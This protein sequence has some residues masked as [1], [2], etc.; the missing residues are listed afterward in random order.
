M[1]RV[2]LI[3][4]FL[5]LFAG[6][7]PPGMIPYQ[8]TL[9][10]P[11]GQVLPNQ[12]VE[13]RFVIHLNSP[14]NPVFEEVHSAVSD[15]DGGVALF[16]GGGVATS[17]FVPPL[18]NVGWDENTGG[19]FLQTF[20][21]MGDAETDVGITQLMSVPF[22]L[23]AERSGQ[24]MNGKSVMGLL[25]DDQL[26]Y[27]D[28]S[29]FIIPGLSDANLYYERGEGV[30]DVDGNYYKS[31]VIQTEEGPIEFTTTN[32]RSTKLNDGTAIPSDSL[33]WVEQ[34]ELS[35]A[36]GDTVDGFQW[37]R[38]TGDTVDGLLQEGLIIF[39]SDT[40]DGIISSDTVDGYISFR[41]SADSAVQR[42]AFTR[43]YRAET[44]TG[45]FLDVAGENSN[46]LTIE[47]TTLGYLY[48]WYAVATGQLCP[49]GWHAPTYQEFNLLLDA[50]DSNAQTLYLQPYILQG[51][52]SE[53]NTFY[54]PTKRSEASAPWLSASGLSLGGLGF[55][56]LMNGQINYAGLN[57]QTDIGYRYSLLETCG[58]CSYNLSTGAFWTADQAL[59]GFSS[60]CF[61]QGILPHGLAFYLT[62]FAQLDY[63]PRDSGLSVRCVRD[64]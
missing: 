51:D 16:I 36:T 55:V 39:G 14:D 20:V 49:V 30:T 50:L 45:P 8:F 31:A 18:Q 9:R 26:V 61:N 57:M 59:F 58:E 28:S 2:L 35:F 53:E 24:M 10:S 64:R 37:I 52:L 29:I 43:P 21:N 60:D 13:V 48:N 15:D 22:A 34:Q 5:P 11:Q 25:P 33:R 27:T 32:L 63:K 47:D 62:E 17:P 12:T 40:V 46:C 4:I 38:S 6:A 44:Q 19:M 7:Q 1:L 54:L 56:S 41:F 42:M 3:L 23:A